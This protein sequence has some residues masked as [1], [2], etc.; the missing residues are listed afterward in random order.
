MPWKSSD[1]QRHSKKA[2]SPRSQRIWKDV[3]NRELKRSGNEGRAVRIAN[4][5]VKRQSKRGPQRSNR[6]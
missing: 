6:R 2:D 5:V 1:A 4:Y 3:A